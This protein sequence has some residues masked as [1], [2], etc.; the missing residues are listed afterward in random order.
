MISQSDLTN[1]IKKEYVSRVANIV[2]DIAEIRI[3]P[4]LDFGEFYT[5]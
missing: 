1:S 5:Y 2:E 4:E 3:K